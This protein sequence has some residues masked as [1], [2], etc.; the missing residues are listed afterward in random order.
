MTLRG[1]A[2]LTALFANFCWSVSFAQQAPA[3]A[4]E[5]APKWFAVEIT[6]GAKWDPAKPANQQAFRRNTPR[7]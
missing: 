5:P 1:A 7:I 3:L 4:P 6:T 2:F